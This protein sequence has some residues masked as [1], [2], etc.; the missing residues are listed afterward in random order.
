MKRSKRIL[1]LLLSIVLILG[2]L[3]MFVLAADSTFSDVKTFDWFYNDVKYVC[4]K[5]LMKGTSSNT[6]SPKATTSRGMIV[7]ILYRMAGEPAVTGACSFKDVTAGSYYEK[8]VI[9]AVENEVVG[10][11]SASTFDPDGAITRE[12][13]AAILYRYAKFCGYDVTA[14]A[15]IDMFSDAGTVSSYALTAMKWA[16]A[17]GLIN[18]SG[19][20]LDPQGSATRAQVA[21]ILM[22][23]C[24][25][26]TLTTLRRSLI[27]APARVLTPVVPAADI[28]P[29]RGTRGVRTP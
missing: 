22:R 1:S 21:A 18:G 3:P 27:P 11:Y 12:Q 24:E 19:S 25:D 4:E 2:M 13:L 15:E 14:S 23:F 10:G 28:H 5:G 16:S 7:T 26:V 20:K 8:P 29:A 17:E 6:F 9:W